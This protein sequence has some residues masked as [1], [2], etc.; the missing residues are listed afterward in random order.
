M[1]AMTAIQ[2]SDRTN[3]RTRMLRHSSQDQS[4][5]SPTQNPVKLFSAIWQENNSYILSFIRCKPHG[6]DGHSK[7]LWT[8][9]ELHKFQQI[10]SIH[11]PVNKS[12]C[13][14]L[15]KTRKAGISYQIVQENTYWWATEDCLIYIQQSIIHH[16]VWPNKLSLCDRNIS[17][18]SYKIEAHNAENV[19]VGHK[20]GKAS[21]TWFLD[22]NLLAMSTVWWMTSQEQNIT[23]F[24]AS[25]VK[26]MH[27][28]FILSTWMTL[29]KQYICKHKSPFRSII[30]STHF[31]SK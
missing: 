7:L 1:Q 15:S 23:G 26:Y 9:N 31:P 12:C 4:S 3:N 17:V 29:P 24:E 11:V 28:H 18:K 5:A 21:T 19:Q 16:H 30:A 14:Y 27:A 20:L 2:V 6:Q 10:L 22:N 25:V 8:L 13:I